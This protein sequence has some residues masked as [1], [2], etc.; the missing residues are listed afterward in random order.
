MNYELMNNNIVTLSGLFL[1]DQ[2]ITK[3]LEKV[4][5]SFY[6][7]AEIKR[8]SDILP[9]TISERLLPDERCLESNLSLSLDNCEVIIKLLTGNQDFCLRFLLGIFWTMT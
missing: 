2:S 7:S 4:L 3:C 8:T 6:Y 9:I 1:R 5:R